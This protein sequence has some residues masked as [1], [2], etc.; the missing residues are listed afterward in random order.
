MDQVRYTS[1]QIRLWED[2]MFKMIRNKSI[3]HHEHIALNIQ[4]PH[5][6]QNSLSVIQ[7]ESN[8]FFEAN[9]NEGEKSGSAV[10]PINK[11]ENQKGSV[12]IVEPEN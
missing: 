2:K 11:S 5:P 4:N 12:K 1:L 9:V 3:L 8:S 10:P 6:D 7:P